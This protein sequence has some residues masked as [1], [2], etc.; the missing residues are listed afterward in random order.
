MR[1]REHFGR[2]RPKVEETSQSLTPSAMPTNECFQV[3]PQGK[4]VP[5]LSTFLKVDRPGDVLAMLLPRGSMLQKPRRRRKTVKP[6]P[7][8]I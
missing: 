6:M 4:V 5:P 2:L 1:L 8:S 7:S 3:S